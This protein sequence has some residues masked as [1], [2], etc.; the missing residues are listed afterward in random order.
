MKQYII[1]ELRLGEYKKIKTY[2]DEN[3]GSSKIDGIY[4]IQLDE[5]ILTDIQSEHKECQPF[6]FAIDIGPKHVSCELLV[7]SRSTIKCNCT[8]YA[9][10][11]QRNWIIQFAD[12]IFEKLDIAT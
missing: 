7:R 11:S 1:D 8:S 10:E 12:A 6:Y 4:W 2:L 3:V 9:T 5:N